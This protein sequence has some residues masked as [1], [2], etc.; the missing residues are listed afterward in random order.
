MPAAEVYG[1]GLVP[2]SLFPR[3]RSPGEDIAMGMALVR[4]GVVAIESG[5]LAS[6]FAAEDVILISCTSVVRDSICCSLA[7]LPAWG[8]VAV[9]RETW[10]I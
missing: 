6:P 9:P 8:A 5:V 3:D 2:V 1:E 10:L 7:L 4:T